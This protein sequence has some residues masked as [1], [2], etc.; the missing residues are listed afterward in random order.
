MCTQ[1]LR[2]WI[3]EAIYQCSLTSDD[4]LLRYEPVMCG[5]QVFVVVFL[6]TDGAWYGNTSTPCPVFIP[7]PWNL[8]SLVLQPILKQ[9]AF[10]FY[11]SPQLISHTLA[12]RLVRSLPDCCKA[13]KSTWQL[14]QWHPTGVLSF[15]GML[16]SIPF[17][18]ISW[19][20][21]IFRNFFPS[22]RHMHLF[23]YHFPHASD[24]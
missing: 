23:N 17:A 8:L 18:F 10:A 1:Y 9:A 4:A 19:L 24:P 13:M 20:I 12:T 11:V 5:D 15:N 14:L 7:L 21:C 22:D 6:I 2:I 16:L 3:G